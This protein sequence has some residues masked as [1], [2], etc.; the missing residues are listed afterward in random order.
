MKVYEGQG[1]LFHQTNNCINK[2]GEKGS[3]FQKIM[4]ELNSKPDPSRVN[5]GKENI[6]PLEGGV[7]ILY[8][9]ENTVGSQN[10]A[11]ELPLVAELQETLD[12]IDFYS[13][14]LADSSISSSGLSPLINHLEERLEGLRGME[15]TPETSEKLRSII[16]D[17]VIT[18]GAEV[19]KF[20]RGDYQ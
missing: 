16:S 1:P 3:D 14:K 20:K 15:S 13:S 11:K 9:V 5:P 12:L 6:V 18:I 2:K 17:M 7:Q 8:G 19:A 10:S 4:E